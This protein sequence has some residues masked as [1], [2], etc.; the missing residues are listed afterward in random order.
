MSR[1]YKT[2][3]VPATTRQE[4]VE[5]C[6]DLCGKKAN[7]DDWGDNSYNFDETDVQVSI[8]YRKGEAY[9]SGGSEVA[10]S[11]DMCPTCFTQKLVPWLKSQ[12]V[13]VQAISSSW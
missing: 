2:V 7:S 13:T 9:P 11:I 12:G 8:K 1:T 10:C 3:A 6:C 5:R 4:L